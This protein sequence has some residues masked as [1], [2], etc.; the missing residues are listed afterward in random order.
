MKNWEKKSKTPDPA[1]LKEVRAPYEKEIAKLNK[2]KK[3][4]AA[5]KAG[6]L[7]A[8]TA[9]HKK[10]IEDLN[11]KKAAALANSKGVDEKVKAENAAIAKK[12]NEIRGKIKADIAKC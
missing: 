10:T 4:L 7:S 5:E 8:A 12:Y 6:K 1:K 11:A 9:A 2:E 3:N